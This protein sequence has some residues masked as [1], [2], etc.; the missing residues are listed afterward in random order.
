MGLVDQVDQGI[1]GLH[2]DHGIAGA[3]GRPGG[4]GGLQV[5][6]RVGGFR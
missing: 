3:P 1:L 2:V 5:D 4:I 6:Y